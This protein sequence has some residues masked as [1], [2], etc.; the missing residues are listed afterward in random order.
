M[1][2]SCLFRTGILRNVNSFNINIRRTKTENNEYI[3]IYKFPYIRM[4]SLVNR[5]KFFQTA[6]TGVAVPTSIVCHQ[7]NVVD[8]DGVLFTAALGWFILILYL[9]KFSF[10]YCRFLQLPHFIQ[11]RLP[12]R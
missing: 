9:N 7:F 12:L 10:N 2:R 6:L 5:L 3:P 11:F 1:Y 4:F 8:F